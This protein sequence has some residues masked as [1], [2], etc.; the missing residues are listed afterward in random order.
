MHIWLAVESADMDTSKLI[1][2]LGALGYPGSAVEI[3]QRC[4]EETFRDATLT[5]A[6]KA[7]ERDQDERY[8]LHVLTNHLTSLL[9]PH[10]DWAQLPQKSGYAA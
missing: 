6:R 5:L 10:R 2:S 3:A 9:W 1:N 4:S 7:R 8:V